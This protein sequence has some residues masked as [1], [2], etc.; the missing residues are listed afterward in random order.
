MLRVEELESK[1]TGNLIPSDKM[2]NIDI[3]NEMI[4]E[5]KADAKMFP[6]NLIS[7]KFKTKDPAALTGKK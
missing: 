5:E 4:V 6:L 7:N 1:Q 3:D 2:G